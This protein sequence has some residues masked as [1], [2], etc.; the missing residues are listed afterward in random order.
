VS[1]LA[2]ART[3]TVDRLY[4]DF[5]RQANADL[6]FQGKSVGPA[7]AGFQ[8]GCRDSEC[9]EKLSGGTDHM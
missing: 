7:D 8:I 3:P 1:R 2:A 6:E 4:V 5:V 9:P